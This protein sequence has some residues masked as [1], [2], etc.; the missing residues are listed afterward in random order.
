[1]IACFGGII[2]NSSGNR[3]LKRPTLK[4]YR[5]PVLGKV[6]LKK[7]METIEHE[8]EILE[9]IYKNS[10]QVHQRDLAHIV[11]LSIG[12]TNAILKRLV[13]KGLL[14]VKKVNN[15]NIQYIVSPGVW[16]KYCGVVTDILSGL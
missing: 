4:A 5:E 12:M 2:L 8:L 6:C 15:R 7:T 16:R 14:K 11:G 1:M 10:K 3:P 9:N 13:K